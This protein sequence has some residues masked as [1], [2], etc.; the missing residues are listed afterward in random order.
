MR[1]KNFFKNK[2]KNIILQQKYTKN[3]R[4]NFLW[5]KVTKLY[6]INQFKNQLGS[7]N[8]I[9]SVCKINGSLKKTNKKTNVSRHTIRWQKNTKFLEGW[10]TKEW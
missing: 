10:T 8:K 7:I 4:N 6:G 3:I 9:L 2:Q 5:N 1:K